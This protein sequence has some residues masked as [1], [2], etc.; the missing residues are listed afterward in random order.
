M[1]LWALGNILY[2][3]PLQLAYC[4]HPFVCIS[5]SFGW[6]GVSGS[7][8]FYLI[9]FCVCFGNAFLGDTFFAGCSCMNVWYGAPVLESYLAAA[10]IA[11]IANAFDVD[12]A[13]FRFG[14]R[15][16]NA[17]RAYPAPEPMQ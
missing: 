9:L 5:V 16:C 10:E 15:T 4:N 3:W 17:P 14:L 6:Y 8:I 7:V 1:S 13:G 11:F 2:V 12:R